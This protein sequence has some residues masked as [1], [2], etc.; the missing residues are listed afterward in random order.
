[1]RISFL[2]RISIDMNGYDADYSY[3][4]SFKYDRDTRFRK[5]FLKEYGAL[6][7]RKRC[8]QD[9]KPAPLP[10]QHKNQNCYLEVLHLGRNVAL[11]DIS[12][13]DLRENAHNSQANFQIFER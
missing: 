6:R 2:E 13:R 1:M 11:K 8:A 4:I 9:T 5:D 3:S 7:S 10:G 12:L